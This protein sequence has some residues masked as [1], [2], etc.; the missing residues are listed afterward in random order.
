MT[1]NARNQRQSD[2]PQA[3]KAVAACFGAPLRTAR[4]E[5]GLRL[6]QIAA[7][8]RIR[9]EIL[10]AIEEEDF[11]RLPPEPFLRG[12]V[13]SYARAVGVEAEEIVKGYE[14]CRGI[15][16]RTLLSPGSELDSRRDRRR[17][18]FL[19]ALI[20]LALLVGGSLFAHRVTVRQGGR[21]AESPEARAELL[22]FPL[23]GQ[24][25]APSIAA[26]PPEAPRHELI[27]SAQEDGWIKVSVDQG[28]PR[29]YALRAG[30]QLTLEARSGF[31][32]LIGNAGGVRLS[33]DGKPLPAAGRRG[34]VVNLHLP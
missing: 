23:P 11:E 3:E 14:R 8:T 1:R 4:M 19:L 5:R 10:Q 34:Q 12:F 18:F 24:A 31:N 32:L 33:L 2:P 30:M 25:P 6:E 7:E 20:L 29:E 17:R 16:H 13:R 15:R 22:A 28:T 21:G 26:S 9:P 27:V